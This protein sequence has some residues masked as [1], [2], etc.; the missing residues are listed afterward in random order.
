MK[1]KMRLGWLFLVVLSA[2]CA[3]GP[4]SGRDNPDRLRFETEISR[5]ARESQSIRDSCDLYARD[6]ESLMGKAQADRKLSSELEYRALKS[7]V[8][9]YPGA[10]EAYRDLSRLVAAS[11][12]ESDWDLSPIFAAYRCSPFS[13]LKA[14]EVLLA[15]CHEFGITERERE[16][17]SRVLLA[18]VRRELE[19]PSNLMSMLLALGI[20]ERMHETGLVEMDSASGAP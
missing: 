17:L 2:G 5:L 1:T 14:V 6:V 9:G 4:V 19:A 15:S 12:I 11:G 3:Q 10:S 16:G 20:L 7:R 18:Q 8:V 13:H